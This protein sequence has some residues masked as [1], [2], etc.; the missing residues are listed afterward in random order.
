MV[1]LNAHQ[2]G[3]SATYPQA[4][5]ARR[6]ALLLLIAGNDHAASSRLARHRARTPCGHVQLRFLVTNKL[7]LDRF[8]EDWR[9]KLMCTSG[10]CPRSA[11]EESSNGIGGHR[12]YRGHGPLVHNPCPGQWFYPSLFGSGSS[13]LG[14]AL[15]ADGFLRQFAWLRQANRGSIGAKQTAK[16]TKKTPPTRK[17]ARSAA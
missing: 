10:P 2:R 7:T 13:G 14:F 12:P 3:E 6:L 1:F 16:M 4:V 5:L 8:C 9:I 17:Q 15:V 11:L